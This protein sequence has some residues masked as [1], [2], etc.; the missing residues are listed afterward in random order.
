[1]TSHYIPIFKKDILQ[2]F[3]DNFAPYY[4]TFYEL[5]DY[6]AWAAIIQRELEELLPAP[7]LVLEAGCG[8]GAMLCELAKYREQSCVGVDISAGM[9][10]ICR[11]RL[12]HA[13]NV[14]LVQGDLFALGFQSECFDA[15]VGA[16][17]L[18]NF[19]SSNQRKALLAEMWRVLKPNGIFLTDYFTAHRY[20]Q[21]MQASASGADTSHE[22]S[23][24]SLSQTF[25]E[26][27]PQ[28]APSFAGQD[29][30]KCERVLRIA[31]QA[32]AH[33]LYFLDPQEIALDF[34]AAGF[35]IVKSISLVRDSS[36]S[37]PNRLTLIG[38]KP[39]PSST[40]KS[41]TSASTSFG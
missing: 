4:D 34:S 11:S 19:F 10:D 1:M 14:R 22:D 18:L 20:E 39:C 36:A 21:L 30:L 8:T 28:T 27:S 24:F 17:S 12:R 32:L 37:A 25:P 3:F 31:D 13:H 41:S 38:R 5:I 26:Q 23:S 16:F 35:Q 29:R 15:V 33:P 40:S 2:N 9:L 7:R 6:A